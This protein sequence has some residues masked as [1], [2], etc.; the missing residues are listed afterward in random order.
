MLLPLTECTQLRALNVRMPT[1]LLLRSLLTAPNVSRT[2]QSITLTQPFVRR[3]IATDFLAIFSAL[4][5]LRSLQLIQCNS[6][7]A[8]AILSRAHLAPALRFITLQPNNRWMDDENGSDQLQD[9]PAPAFVAEILSRCAELQRL[10]IVFSCSAQDSDKRT[11]SGAKRQWK[12]LAHAPELAPFGRRF[13]MRFDVGEL[14]LDSTNK[15]SPRN[16]RCC[17]QCSRSAAPPP[18]P[19]PS[20]SA[21]GRV[22]DTFHCSS[23][24]RQPHYRCS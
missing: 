8:I 15:P 10:S 22:V 5:H 1:A 4:T 17:V 6:A 7:T 23:R 12:R 11:Q 16:D 9:L 21:F 18:S 19:S 24:C 3:L 13:H 14:Q 2:L 20:R